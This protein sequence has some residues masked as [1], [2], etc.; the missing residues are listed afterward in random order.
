MLDHA[1]ITMIFLVLCLIAI[2][3]MSLAQASVRVNLHSGEV[4][5]FQ[6]VIKLENVAEI[7]AGDASLA[8]KLRS[9]DLDS[10]DE[11]ENVVLLTKEQ[12]RIRLMLAGIRV[13]QIQ[14]SGPERLTALLV[15]QVS[16]R[17]TV[18]SQLQQQLAEQ[19]FMSADN[20]R[21]KI[22]ER[23]DGIEKTN[24]DFSTLE[25]ESASEPELPLGRQTLSAF[26]LTPSGES[27]SI[28]IPVTVA[29]IRDLVIAKE[30]IS[31]GQTLNA[32]NIEAVRRPVKNRHIRFASFEQVVGKKAQSD[33]QQYALIRSNVVR[34]AGLTQQHAIR[35]NSL[36]NVVVR[37]GPLKVVLKEAKALDNGNPG[38]QITLLNPKTKERIVAKVVDSSTAEVSY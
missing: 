29:Q 4:H 7:Y 37:R 16:V 35:R 15:D 19:F 27:R 10:F 13:D 3:S 9:L 31:K 17:K 23:F 26:G 8:R 14:L 33:V 12:V 18:E 22:D 28:K 25:I 1:R 36:V 30:N 21:V 5:C 32:Q 34:T 2:P 20:L 6:N 11:N 24:L 38:D